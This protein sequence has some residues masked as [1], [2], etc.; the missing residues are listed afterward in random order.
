MRQIIFGKSVQGASHIRS[1][2]ECQDSYKQMVLEDGTIILAVADGHGSKSCPF[3]KTGSRIAVNVFC[4]IMKKLYEGYS[5]VPDQFL[6]YLNREGDTMV[7]RTIDTEW[8][9]R[10]LARH[11]KNKREI[12]M[13]ENGEINLAAIYKQ[14]GSTLLGL[15]ITKDIVFGLQ[16]GD[17]DICYATPDSIQMVVEPEKILG[18]ETYS[19]SGENAW[20]KTVTVARR[21]C[22]EDTLPAVFSLSTD[23]YSNSYKSDEEFLAAIKDY[24]CM[25]EEHGPKAVRDNLSDWLTETSQMGS[26]DDITMLI[27]YFTQSP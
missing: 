19:L 10:V 15:M 14:Y 1:G 7:A 21:I 27:A 24:L 16:L 3:S 12:N 22:I 17:G 8:K 23:G 26:G 6:S 11:R 4:D 9:R 20:K 13:Q 2:T 25:L 18:I 5:E